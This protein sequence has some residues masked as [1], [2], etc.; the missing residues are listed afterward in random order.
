MPPQP[1]ARPLHPSSVYRFADLDELD[2]VSDG[3]EPGFVYAR[4]GHPNAAWLGEK[5]ARLEGAAWAIPC[6]SGMAALSAAILTYVTAGGRIVAADQLYG[7]TAKLLRNELPRL[8]ITT[9]FVDAADLDA[10]REALRAPT[11][12]LLVET[13]SNPLCRVADLSALADIAHAAGAKL[14]VDNTF[15]T[16]IL[17]RPAELGAVLVMESLTKMIGGHSDLLLGSLAGNDPE[18]RQAV[19]AS[20]SSWG[21]S[22]PPFDCWLCERGLATLD[23]RVRTASANALRIAEW[24]QGRPGVR[25]VVYPGLARHPDHAL[26]DRQFGGS[27]GHMLCFE[28]DGG[29]E[30]VNRFV[31]GVP[32]IPLSPSLGDTGTTLSHP[33]STSHRYESAAAKTVLGITP[34]LL[35]MSVGIEPFDRLCEA[36]AVGLPVE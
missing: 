29:R 36:L 16:P 30:A 9:T 31:R 13:I 4:D 24:L 11:Q 14:V 12:V 2:R 32:E 27:F 20:V 22:A 23:L 10:V 33:D 19:A 5:L 34:G 1:L 25:R 15:A 18:L 6:G 26:A 17:C 35:R 3:V 21:F 7:R 8:G 28:L